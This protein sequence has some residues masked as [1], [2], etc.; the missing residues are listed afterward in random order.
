MIKP[1]KNDM[2]VTSYFLLPS[3]VLFDQASRTKEK[4]SRFPKFPQKMH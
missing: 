4:G 1:S 2:A 3:G